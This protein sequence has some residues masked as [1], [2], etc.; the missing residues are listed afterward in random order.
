VPQPVTQP[1]PQTPPPPPPATPLPSQQAQQALQ[2]HLVGTPPDTSAQF[3]QQS[4]EVTPPLTTQSGQKTFLDAANQLAMMYWSALG[5][6]PSNPQGQLAGRPGMQT[7][8]LTPQG[9]RTASGYGASGY[10]PI[11]GV[12]AT[13]SP[14]STSIPFPPSP[15]PTD[16]G[17]GN[18]VLN[19]NA[20]Q[21][22]SQGGQ[23]L[24]GQ[25]PPPGWTGPVPPPNVMQQTGKTPGASPTTTSSSTYS[26]LQGPTGNVGN[27]MGYYGQPPSAGMGLY[28]PSSSSVSQMGAQSQSILGSNK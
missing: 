16:Q 9:Q 28:L 6:S 4:G 26:P 21:I 23:L 20:Q 3:Q 25:N 11:G 2:P 12:Q 19:P 15:M 5:Q 10:M 27:P 18:F 13:S 17:M 1:A 8:T 14:T 7:P 22:A 24:P